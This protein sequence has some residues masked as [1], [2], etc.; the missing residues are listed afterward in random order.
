MNTYKWNCGSVEVYTTYTDGQGNTEPLVI[1]KVNWEI[2]VCDETG[3]ATTINGVEELNIGNLDN[4]TSFDQVTNAQVTEWV[5]ASMGESTVAANESLADQA[6][7]TFINPVTQE[8]MLQ[9]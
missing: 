6:L 3:N 9:D 2:L 4:F 1:F 8:L 7:N 5:K